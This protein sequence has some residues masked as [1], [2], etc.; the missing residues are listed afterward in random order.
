M[1]VTDMKK[2]LFWLC[3]G[4]LINLTPLPA[5]AA[6]LTWYTD[7]S[8]AETL[9]R[10]EKKSVLLFFHG[11]DWCPPCVEMQHQVID[12]PEFIAYARQ[13]LVLVDV[14]FPE[15]GKQDEALKRANRA[16]KAKFNVGEAYPTLVLLDSTGETVYQ[17][18]GYG[19]DGPEEVL[20]KLERHTTPPRSIAQSGY[21]DLNVA[22][23]AKMAANK[24]NVILDVRTAGE[25]ERGHI[26]GAVNLDYLSPY[27]AQKARALDKSKTYLVHC[28]TGV[29]SAR[30]CAK[31]SQLDFPKLYNLTGGFKAWVKAGEPMVK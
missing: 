18:A 28:A 6:K 5:R 8:Q 7:L 24:Q 12:S 19:G 10:K 26:A 22:E 23:F 21:K 11:S 4:I 27:F 31:L 1:R 29:R 9:A 2:T 13:A 30:A 3:F 16:L 25:F 14:D 15:K 17:E 20:P